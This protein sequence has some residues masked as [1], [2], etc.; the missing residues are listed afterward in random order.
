[1]KKT[2]I[3]LLIICLGTTMLFGCTKDK[4]KSDDVS[5]EDNNN[6]NNNSSDENNNINN[7]KDNDEDVQ[8][9]VKETFLDENQ[10][11]T[12]SDSIQVVVNKNRNLSSE[13]APEDLVKLE[14]VPTVLSNPEVNQL[15]KEAAEALTL[16]FKKAK[17]ELKIQLYARSGYRS[18]N[19]QVALYNGYVQR[20]GKA[21]ADTFSAKPGQSEHQ[22]GLAMDITSDS[23][24]KQLSEKFGETKEGKWINENAYKYG[25]ILRYPEGKE[26]ITGYIYEPWHIRYLGKDLAKKVFDSGLTLDQYLFG[27][28]DEQ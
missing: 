1:M 24:N 28:K 2:I 27:E 18:Y 17:E 15:R 7:D 16:L 13:Y 4:G 6:I 19:T 22:T 10:V 20:H 8:E 3:I 21:A 25:F 26:D 14:D 12:N 23:V 9:E 11:V 5:V